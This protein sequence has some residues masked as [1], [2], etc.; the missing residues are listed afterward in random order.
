MRQQRTLPFGFR[1]FYIH[2]WSANGP[3]PRSLFS[4]DADMAVRR[5]AIAGLPP[6]YCLTD[7]SAGRNRRRHVPSLVAIEAEAAAL[8]LKLRLRAAR[9]RLQYPK[10]FSV[11]YLRRFLNVLV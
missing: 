6:I 11:D 9:Q 4:V 3:M 7:R 5:A 10:G 2:A 1:D 8:W